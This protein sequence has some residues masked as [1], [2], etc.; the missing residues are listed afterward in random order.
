MESPHLEPRVIL[1]TGTRKGIGAHLVEYYLAKGHQVI[2]C[3]RGQTTQASDNYRHF[4][5]DVSDEAGVR[6][7]FAEISSTYGRLDVLINN[8]GI[9]SMNHVLLTPVTKAREIIETN[10]I[11]TF[12]MCREAARLMRKNRFGRIINFATVATPLKLEGEAV[13]AASKAAVISFTQIIAREF[14]DF[15]ITVNVVAPTPI[16][17]DLIKSVPQE[18]ID[19]LVERQA[20]K[21]LGEFRDVSNVID[22]FIQPESDF[23]T[24]QVLFLG[25]V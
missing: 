13:Y 19:A 23:I 9:A 21:R 5:L 7:M 14:A 25:G 18:K 11:G 3:S 4:C 10:F 12:L 8:A 22:F 2:G 17:T 24:G 16:R 20:V 6:Q 1:I 15:G